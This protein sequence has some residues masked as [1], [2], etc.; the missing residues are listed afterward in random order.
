MDTPEGTVIYV[1]GVSLSF[2]LYACPC[3]HSDYGVSHSFSS[4]MHGACIKTVVRI[5]H[6][7]PWRLL[8]FD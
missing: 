1:H 6:V 5:T 8:Y 4:C 2:S 3:T 7:N